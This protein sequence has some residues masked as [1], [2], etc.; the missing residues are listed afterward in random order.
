MCFRLCVSPP[1]LVHLVSILFLWKNVCTQR[2][3]GQALTGCSYN[4]LRI[5][6]A[7]T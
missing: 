6:F 1:R 3:T 5:F 4:K 7:L 2:E